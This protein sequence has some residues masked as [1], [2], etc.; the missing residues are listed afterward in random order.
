MAISK[1]EGDGEEISSASV[2]IIP[3][4]CWKLFPVDERRPQYRA[5]AEEAGE[6]GD[7]PERPAR[8]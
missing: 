1:R 2:P 3:S 7:D 5:G 4:T 8:K 6:G